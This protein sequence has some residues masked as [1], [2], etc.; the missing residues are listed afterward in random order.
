MVRKILGLINEQAFSSSVIFRLANLEPK[1]EN[2]ITDLRHSEFS[3]AKVLALPE[4][5]FERKLWHRLYFV[6][7]ETF[8]RISS[9]KY[10]Q[11]GL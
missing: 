10:L 8:A 11:A 6:R 3:L 5:A 4:R 9:I 1:Y 7:I 2:N